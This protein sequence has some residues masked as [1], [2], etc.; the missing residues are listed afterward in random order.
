ME[1]AEHL[2]LVSLATEAEFECPL[3]QFMLADALGLT[4]IHIN[5][6]LRQ[7]WDD[8]LVAFRK[9]SVRI[10]DLKRLRNNS[11]FVGG[12]WNSRN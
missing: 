7:L 4:A 3:N 9:G 6:I 12:Y 10:H 11:G 2:S 1:L 5:R 8:E